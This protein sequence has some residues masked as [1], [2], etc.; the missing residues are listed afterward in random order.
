MIRNEQ[1]EQLQQYDIVSGH[2]KVAD[3]V[4]MGAQARTGVPVDAG[5]CIC[6]IEIGK[7]YKSRLTLLFC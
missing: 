3:G 5:G 6:I 4:K 1:L 7:C 2:S